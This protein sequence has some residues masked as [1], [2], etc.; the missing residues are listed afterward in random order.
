MSGMIQ[1]VTA[2]CISI[3]KLVSNVQNVSSLPGLY[4]F[5]G[6]HYTPAF[7]GKGKVKPM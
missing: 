2:E 3:K 1:D 7:F 6:N 5:S 4:A